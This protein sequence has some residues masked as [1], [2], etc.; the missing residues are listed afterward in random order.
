M[1]IED[2]RLDTVV[3][4]NEGHE[5]KRFSP[6]EKFIIKAV[7]QKGG[8]WWAMPIPVSEDNVL[9]ASISIDSISPVKTDLEQ[10]EE[11]I[12]KEVHAAEV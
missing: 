10:L 11:S 3:Q 1:K 5:G 2:V 4:V 9:G 7:Y 6:G 12:K 8:K